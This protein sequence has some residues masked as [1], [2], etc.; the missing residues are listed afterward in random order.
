MNNIF[1]TTFKYC[2]SLIAAAIWR[3]VIMNNIFRNI[4]IISTVIL[5][6]GTSAMGSFNGPLSS[7]SKPN[8]RDTTLY[9]GGGGPGNY[10]CIQDAIDNASNGYTIIVFS[11][12]YI[13]NQIIINKAVRIQGAGFAS[14][15]IDGSNA[16][17]S[18]CGVVRIIADGDVTFSG[19][20]IQN[21]GT[22]ES[23][24]R[25]GIYASSEEPSATYHIFHNMI[26]GT[27]NPNDE[28]DYGFYSYGGQETLLFTNNTMTQHGSNPILLEKHAGETDVS[29]NI[30]DEGV[31]GSVVYFSMTYDNQDITTLQRVSYN[32]INL[33]TGEHTGSDYISGG[34]IFRSA[35][36]GTPGKYTNIEITQNTIYNMK[37]YRRAISLSNDANGSG[38]D[39]EISAPVIRGNRIIGMDMPESIGLQLRGL[40]SNV[41]I[42]ENT[43]TH[44]EKS[45]FGTEGV[46]SPGVYPTNIHANYDNFENNSLGFVWG[47]T[48]V[49]NAEYNWWGNP[50]GP[51]HAGNPGGIGDG[52]SDT[53]DY[54]PWL[55][56][57]CGPPYADYVYNI[58]DRTVTFNA[59]SSC[60]Y[61]GTITSYEWN[62]GD[63]HTDEGICVTHIF[64]TYQT[65]LVT[66]T[67]TDNK[68]NIDTCY[69]E[70]ALY[71]YIPPVLSMIQDTPDP[72]HIDHPV[73]ITCTAVDN[74]VIATVIVH[75]IAPD[76]VETTHA[77]TYNSMTHHAYYDTIY[78]MLGIYSYFIWT[79]DTNGNS[80]I[81]ATYSFGVTNNP[82]NLPTNPHPVN[83][84]TNVN[85][86]VT[87]SWTGTDPDP[88]DTTTYDVFFG[89]TFPLPKMV[90]NISTN[91]Y[92][93][94]SLL[95]QTTYYW[96]IVSWDPY[97]A[98]RIGPLWYFMTKNAPNI[99]PNTPCNPSPS[100][101]QTSVSITADLSWTGGD[102]NPADNVTY[103][104]FFG[105][106]N[107]PLKVASNQTSLTYDPSTLSFGTS[108]YWK[109]IAWD[110]H[111]AHTDGPVWSFTTK[112]NSAPSAP[113]I[114]GP[115]SGTIGRTYSYTFVAIDPEQNNV[116][117]EIDWGDGNVDPWYGPFQSNT[118]ITRNHTWAESGSFLIKARAK[119]ING[120]IGAWGSLNI[121]MPTEIPQQSTQSQQVSQPVQTHK[122]LM[123]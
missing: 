117:Y 31:Y 67:V 28:G 62:F 3:K 111:Q 55:I 32:D 12:T 72:Q 2:Y 84:A 87:L 18:E 49:L 27:N 79:N 1:L 76:A 58:A 9:V 48:E 43:I 44:C 110:N 122:I 108:Y 113:I 41:V 10:T 50:S 29:Y 104:I 53:V 16:L 40:I 22:T 4:V 33:G 92:Q 112:Q 61:D 85:L 105:T 102:P 20:T 26:I 115:A 118:I 86:T 34:I 80:V 81:S 38:V 96:Y 23:G 36:T 45:F 99:P 78:S 11:G 57:P 59:S 91:S 101:G 60:D 90:N 70:L 37:G 93:F 97:G 83:G 54:I 107:P 52:V 100:N 7:H 88:D 6:F 19:F 14:T 21:P 56:H 42:Q 75:I 71:D 116:S 77:M 114:N 106:S 98:S 17:L 120:A 65:Y 35:F 63:T 13:E 15:I 109:I 68:E 73:N 123:R 47:G 82:P 64:S 119:D 8:N 74:V 30:L 25:M 5:F 103:D 24:N 39:S 94:S 69:Q 95:Y 51:T 66:L 89:T 46:Q 121:R